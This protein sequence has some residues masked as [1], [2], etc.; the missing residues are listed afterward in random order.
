[1][2]VQS[3][4]SSGIIEKIPP[5]RT[6][7]IVYNHTENKEKKQLYFSAIDIFYTFAGK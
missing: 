5:L 1:M 3:I 4:Y 6:H 2:Q 7:Q